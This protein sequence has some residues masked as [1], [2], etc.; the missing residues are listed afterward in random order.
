MTKKYWE[1]PI[2]LRLTPYQRKVLSEIVDGAQDAGA[3]EGGLSKTEANALHSIFMRLIGSSEKS[4]DVADTSPALGMAGVRERTIKEC[5]AL[6]E[7]SQETFSETHS[8][9][10]RH[11]TPRKHG[12][13]AGLAYADGIRALAALS[14][15]TSTQDS[16]TRPDG[17]GGAGE[18]RDQHLESAE[19]QKAKS[20][21]TFWVERWYAEREKN[22]ALRVALA[23]KPA[24]A[25][26]FKNGDALMTELIWE[27]DRAV[28]QAA[29][30]DGRYET[31]VR[32]IL[33][34]HLAPAAV[35][36]V[37]E[38][39]IAECAKAISDTGG[40]GE[41]DYQ[42][43]YLRAVT[44]LSSLP[45]GVEVAPQRYRHRV[46]G[47]TYRVL[48]EAAKASSI[49]NAIDGMTM[50]IYQGED[51][52]LIWVRSSIE[53]FDGR[54]EALSPDNSSSSRNVTDSEALSTGGMVHR[55]SESASAPIG[56]E[57][58]EK[59]APVASGERA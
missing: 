46:R 10:R 29:Q 7:R 12:N 11:L 42:R 30:N 5:A 50:V 57:A 36:E 41:C 59:D 39:T 27:I 37:R 32:H 8:G 2:T 51:D 14:P 16:P 26:T 31:I 22:C 19:I 54:F 49:R 40:C 18:T 1:K 15:A 25:G 48:Y 23:A 52:G 13:S 3:C 56:Q 9:S 24:P 21:L 44:A 38:A 45:A 20:N 35:W 58:A 33:N 47:T 53:F 55:T 17:V 6:V 43:I 4:T 34:K 28:K